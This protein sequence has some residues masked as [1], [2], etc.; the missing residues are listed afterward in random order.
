MILLQHVV[1][2]AGYLSY[3]ITDDTGDWDDISVS[4]EQPDP[5]D[6]TD[7]DAPEDQLYGSFNASTSDQLMVNETPS[8][9]RSQPDQAEVGDQADAVGSESVSAVEVEEFPFGRP[10]APIPGRAQD[11]SEY[12][13]QAASVG[14]VW[15]PFRSQL[16]WDVARWAK[17]RGGSSTA[18]SELLAIPGVRATFIYISQEEDRWTPCILRPV[19]GNSTSRSC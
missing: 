11:P 18:V 8:D 15:A 5:A 9:L 7:T 17:L 16:E 2:S 19:T 14:S 12:E 1:H 3:T 13:S 6:L 10:G 4:I